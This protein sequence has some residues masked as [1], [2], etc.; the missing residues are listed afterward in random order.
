MDPAVG[1]PTNSDNTITLANGLKINT[2]VVQNLLNQ[3]ASKLLKEPACMTN[4]F[5]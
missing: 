3:K 2:N 4:H 1:A 5:F